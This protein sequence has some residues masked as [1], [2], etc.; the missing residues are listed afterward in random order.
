MLRK[1]FAFPIFNEMEAKNK[2]L[3]LFIAIILIAA[4]GYFYWKYQSQKVE[5]P[6][7]IP[8]ETVKQPLSTTTA[9]TLPEINPQSNP[10]ENK[11]PEINPVERANPF[12]N[13][14]KNPFE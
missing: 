13:I 4:G 10:V 14:Y 12:K 8:K 3:I 11:I 9:G 2:N 7:E 1:C 6:E 5:I